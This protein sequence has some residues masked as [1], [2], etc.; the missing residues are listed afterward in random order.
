MENCTIYSH[1]VNMDKV[2]TVLQSHFDQSAIKV[3]GTAE[4]WES[5]VV[6][7]GKK[8]WKPGQT[9]MLRYRQRTVPGYQLPPSGEAIAEN[10]RGMYN[11]VAGIQA[12]NTGLQELLL[13]KIAT[14]NTELTLIADPAFTAQH[15]AVIMQLAKEMDAFLFSGNNGV[16]KTETQGFWDQQGDLLLDTTGASTAATLTVNIASAY[17]DDH[18]A[19]NTPAPD[20]TARKAR[21]EAQLKAMEVK[22]N[23]FLP[24]VTNEATVVIRSAREIAE[25]LVVLSAVNSV[26]FNHFSGAEITTY[27]QKNN[28]WEL[29]TPKEKIFL[30]HPKEADKMRETWKCE[31]IWV[32]LW[33]L[34]KLSAIGA[35][36]ALANLDMI[37]AEDYPFRG[38]EGNPAAYIA[39]AGDMR[40]S[41]EILDANDLYYR[42]DWACV[43]ARIKGTGIEVLHPGIVYERHY[44]LNWLISYHEQ[45]WDEV[46][47]DT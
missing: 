32:L 25:R 23:R 41:A 45:P 30:E 12:A 42:A 21:S 16:F 31:G 44:A 33:A 27:L 29:T 5:V 38:L 9:L 6:T 7:T 35:M 14:I 37:A 17:F 39:A 36:D 19:V 47:C 46:S 26:A 28:L 1:D 15:A 34:K 43:D 20:A 3:N 22:T 2:L 11:Y 18:A 8:L 4:Q 40:S 24:V 10:L 13:A